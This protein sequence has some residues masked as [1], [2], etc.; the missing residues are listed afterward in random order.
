MEIE[1]DVPRGFDVKPVVKPEVKP[2]VKLDIRPENESDVEKVDDSVAIDGVYIDFTDDVYNIFD[3]MSRRIENINIMINELQ[4][5][6]NA[7]LVD[8]QE[9]E[10]ELYY[11]KRRLRSLKRKHGDDSDDS[12]F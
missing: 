9:K 4:Q 8:K 10:K 12:D 3:R 5:K 7:L 6:N 2:E 11:Y 1:T